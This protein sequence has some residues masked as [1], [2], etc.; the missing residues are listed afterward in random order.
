[1]C[2]TRS[3]M[4]SVQTSTFLLTGKSKGGV[5]GSITDPRCASPHCAG[6]SSGTCPARPT[7]QSLKSIPNPSRRGTR[8]PQ[9][10]LPHVLVSGSLLSIPSYPPLVTARGERDAR[11]PRGA[12]VAP[13]RTPAHAGVFAR[14]G[15]LYL[16]TSGFWLGKAKKMAKA[17]FVARL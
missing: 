12:N 2:W 6:A 5:E 8:I 7:K 3:A 15:V 14:H 4:F 11:A 13:S 17:R 1:A 10:G 16:F 9:S